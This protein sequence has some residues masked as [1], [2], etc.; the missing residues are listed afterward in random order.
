MDKTMKMAAAAAGRSPHLP[1]AVG[2]TLLPVAAA[3]RRSP[4]PAVAAAGCSR[5]RRAEEAEAVIQARE[6]EAV[7]GARFPRSAEVAAAARPTFTSSYLVGV[8]VEPTSKLRMIHACMAS[9]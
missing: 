3:V 1:A 5:L 8:G 4:R 6:E 7:V 2:Q 9:A